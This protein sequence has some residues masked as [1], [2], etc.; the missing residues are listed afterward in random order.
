MIFFEFIEMIE[1]HLLMLK[2]KLLNDK[3]IF[4]IIKFYDIHKFK[5]FISII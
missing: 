3:K 4:T 1:I 2:F 5:N